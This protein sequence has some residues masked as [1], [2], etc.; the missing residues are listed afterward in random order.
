MRPGPDDRWSVNAALVYVG[1]RWDSLIPTGG[2]WLEDATDL[3]L[4]LAR[5]FADWEL[6]AVLDNVF[7]TEAEEIVGTP[8]G[9]RRI[10]IGVRFLRVPF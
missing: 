8:I 7:D 2:R 3:Q 6:F 4:T 9:D 1:R 5:K 10:R